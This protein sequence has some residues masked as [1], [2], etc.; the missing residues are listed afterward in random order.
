MTQPFPQA[1]GQAPI[2]VV[3]IGSNS[4]RLVVFNGMHRTPMALFNEKSTCALG[5]GLESSG[6]LNPEGVPMALAA[7]ERFVHL[8]RRMGVERLDVLATAA[9]RDAAD[10]PEFLRTIEQRCAISV[11]LL[12]GEEEALRAAHGV[13]CGVPDADGLVADLGGGSLELILVDHGQTGAFTT[14]PLGV[15]RLADH[16]G[17]DRL[18]AAKMIDQRLSGVEFPKAAKGRSLYAVGGSWRAL[19]RVCIEQMNYPLHVLDNF[20]LPRQEAQKLISIIARQSGKSLDRIQGVSKKRA[21]HLPLSALLLET[22]MKR[23]EP[24]TLVFS[25]H[26]M[27]EGQF[28]LSLPPEMQAEDP[29]LSA[30]RALAQA[31]GRFPEHGNE[32]MDWMSPLFPEES[33]KLARLRHAACLLGDIFWNEHPDYRAEQAFLKV[34]RLPFMGLDHRDRAGLALAVY[35]RYASEPVLPAVQQAMDLLEDDERVRR[36]RA[37]GAAL[38]LGHTLSGGVPGILGRTRLERGSTLLALGVPADDPLYLS[39][40]FEKRLDRLAQE[41]ALRPQIIRV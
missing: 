25:V 9:C 35:F 38:R 36:V 21:V 20:C 41:L 14:L 40:A 19:A 17:G 30:A 24:E 27:R 31:A 37:I 5:T 39:T 8:A 22:L 18:K 15:L 2:G 32:L 4:V 29:L 12:S 7:I 26:G 3:D 6:R 34:L 28:F 23:Y 1:Q 11:S 13:L 33:P 16:S 10:G